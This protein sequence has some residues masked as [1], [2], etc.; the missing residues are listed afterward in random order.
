MTKPYFTQSLQ[1]ETSYLAHQYL[2]TKV[3]PSPELAY[4]L[5]LAFRDITSGQAFSGPSQDRPGAKCT[6][7]WELSPEPLLPSLPPSSCGICQALASQRK[8]LVTTSLLT[9]NYTLE[10]G[11]QLRT[12]EYFPEKECRQG[13]GQAQGLGH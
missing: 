13:W 8:E 1:P 12:E 11:R 10:K 5:C 4:C 9:G 7:S 2:L 3:V 6:Y